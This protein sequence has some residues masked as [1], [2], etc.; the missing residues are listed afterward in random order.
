[1]TFR[2]KLTSGSADVEFLEESGVIR[3]TESPPTVYAYHSNLDMGAWSVKL[4]GSHGELV[5]IL[6]MSTTGPGE[7]LDVKFMDRITGTFVD[8]AGLTGKWN[9]VRIK[10]SGWSQSHSQ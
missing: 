7:W 3:L 5:R 2:Y 4:T 1:V 9:G 10:K 8:D 6:K